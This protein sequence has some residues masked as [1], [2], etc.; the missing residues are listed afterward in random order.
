[1]IATNSSPPFTER[2]QKIMLWVALAIGIAI[3]SALLYFYALVDGDKGL[4]SLAAISIANGNGYALPEFDLLTHQ[5]KNIPLVEWP[6]LY[7]YL[8]TPFLFFTGFNVELSCY[9]L[10]VCAG[11]CLLAFLLLLLRK[12]GFP[13][14]LQALIILFKSAELSSSALISF[15]TDTWAT[16]AVIA[17]F[18]FLLCTMKKPT[19]GIVI[20]FALSNVLPFYF[21]YMYLPVVFVLPVLFTLLQYKDHLFRRYIYLV[22]GITF[23]SVVALLLYNWS[24]S[25]EVVFLITSVRGFYPET[26]KTMAPVFWASFINVDFYCMQASLHTP[27]SYKGFHTLLK[28][29]GAVVLLVL[30]MQ[31]VRKFK[32]LT[33][34]VGVISN[35]FFYAGAL[36]ISLLLF[37]VLLSLMHSPYSIY[38]TRD[39]WTYVM[40]ERYFTVP[41]MVIMIAACWWMFIATSRFRIFEIIARML[42][43]LIVSIEVSHALY[44]IY[45]KSHTDPRHYSAYIYAN[46]QRKLLLKNLFAEERKKGMD[47][48]LVSDQYGYIMQGAMEGVKIS[49]NVA[50]LENEFKFSRPTTLYF[51]IPSERATHF[52]PVILKHNFEWIPVSENYY[53]YKASIIQQ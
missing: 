52:A 48:V 14:W 30:I 49:R 47:I 20:A 3:K 42:F 29:T 36:S 23:T 5:I 44:I 27:L 16:A 13:V 37:I 21:R 33:Q 34:Q 17:A 53:L 43:V 1:M 46:E 8:L 18:Y 39:F 50:A 15:P 10:D 32:S 38:N 28:A 25:E 40:E 35:F 19:T 9:L 12:L 6:P 24:A 11:I 31:Y 2:T 22:A 4:Q 26:L 41:S 51:V 7:S 45:K